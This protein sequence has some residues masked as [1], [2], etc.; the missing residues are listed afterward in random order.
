MD[1][2]NKTKGTARHQI[3]QTNLA[4]AGLPCPFT[5]LQKQ[6]LENRRLRQ[7]LR[8]A[9]KMIKALELEIASKEE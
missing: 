7:L 5:E 3:E 9:R 1:P 4:R 2:K 6:E 8:Q